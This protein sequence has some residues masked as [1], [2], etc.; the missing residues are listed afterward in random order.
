MIQLGSGRYGFGRKP[1]IAVHFRGVVLDDRLG[2]FPHRIPQ[3]AVARAR[4][5]SHPDLK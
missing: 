5:Q 2:E 1:V 4:F 3:G